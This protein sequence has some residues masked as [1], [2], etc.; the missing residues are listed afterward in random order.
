MAVPTTTTLR[1][2]INP[3][4]LGRLPSL[5]LRI[6]KPERNLLLCALHRI[7]PMTDV[8]PHFDCI[9]ATN[10]SRARRKRVCCA[11]H[12]TSLLHYILAF[13]D[14]GTDG[15]AAHVCDETLEERLVGQIGV[16]F[17]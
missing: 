7:T 6:S 12:V 17:L 2:L 9:V 1:L 15:A 11:Q 4:K 8:P 3:I 14:H 10:R 16:M 5:Q 13:P